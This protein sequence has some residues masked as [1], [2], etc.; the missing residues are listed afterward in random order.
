[1]GQACIIIEKKIGETLVYRVYSLTAAFEKEEEHT[2]GDLTK[3][4]ITNVKGRNDYLTPLLVQ[5]RKLRQQVK[6]I[7]DFID[8]PLESAT[9]LS[10]LRE[11]IGG[12]KS[13]LTGATKG[14]LEF[15]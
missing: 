7:T 5:A 8:D 4:R 9:I 1:M 3:V 15:R 12:K 11:V 14:L 6:G 10:E 13:E 2:F